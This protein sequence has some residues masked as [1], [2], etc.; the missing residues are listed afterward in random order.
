MANITKIYEVKLQGSGVLIDEMKQ[1]NKEFTSA[2]EKWKQLKTLISSG[3]LSTAETAKFKAEM[4]AAKLETERLRQEQIRLKNETIALGNANKQTAG[5]SAK[6][7]DGITQAKIET[8][9]LRQET[10]K[11]KNESLALSNAQK[12]QAAEQRKAKEET[13][14][15]T[16]AWKKL[17]AQLNSARNAAKTAGATFGIDSSEFK[18]AA[19]ISNALDA[20]VK[21]IES[22]LGQFQR[23][24]GNYPGNQMLQGLN[25]NTLQALIKS[26]FGS[27]IANQVNLAKERTKELDQQFTLLKN[28]LSAVRTN[29]TGDLDAIQREIMENRVEAQRLNT[30]IGR[31]STEFRNATS[32]GARMSQN[33]QNFFKNLR[34]EITTFLLGYLSFQ[35][36]MAKT[37]ELI[38]NTYELAD[39][40]TSLEVELGKAAGG[41]QKLVDE[42][43][44]LDTRTKLP[45]LVNMGNI[46][47][48]AG[49]EESDVVGVVSAVDKI[50]IAFG[51]DFGEVEKG[52]EDLVKLINVF[53]GG[54]VTEDL[55]LRT[56]NAV[57]TIANE[58]VASV[59][60]LNDFAKRMAG[61]KGI[62][63]IALPAVLGMASGFEQFGQSAETTST[64]IV[65]ILPKIASDVDKFAKITK[66]SREEFS[67][68][69]NESPDQALIKVAEALTKDKKGLEDLIASFR[70]S[71]LAGKGGAGITS[72]IGVL[73]KNA[74]TFQKS[75]M[76]AKNAYA[77]TSNI[78]DAFAKKNENLSASMDK[79]KKGF[80]DA[81]NNQ[82]FQAFLRGSIALITALGGAIGAIPLFAWY[83]LVGLLT[84]AYY[85]NIKA[86][87]IS[88][89]Q[90][91]VYAARTVIGNAL[92][93]ASNVLLRAQT[94][95]IYLAN[96]AW[97]VL[98]STMLYLGTIFPALRT[99]WINLNLTMLNTPIGYIVAGIAA[100]GALLVAMS[101]TTE[102]ASEAIRRNGQAIKQTAAE[103]RVNA[104]VTR[105][106]TEATAD[107][108]SKFETLTRI[109][110]DNNINLNTR[111]T[112]LQEL[113]NLNPQYLNT[114]TLENIKTKEGTDL[115]RK[116]KD[117][118]LDVAKAKASQQL[119]DDKQKK[120]IENELKI[121]ELNADLSKRYGKNVGGFTQAKNAI[122]DVIR[123]YASDLGMGDGDI[124]KQIINLTNENKKLKEDTDV[125]LKKVVDNT[126]KGLT[127]SITGGSAEV[128]A[129]KTLSALRAEVQA[130]QEEFDQTEVKSK[131]WYELQKDIA[132][133]NAYIDSLTKKDKTPKDKASRL[134]G[135]QKDFVKD[136]DAAN[137]DRL[138]AIEDNFAKG[139][140]LEDQ[141]IK[142]SLASNIKY[143]DAKI[144]YLK[145]GNAEERKQ[146]AQAGYDKAKMERE[147]NDKLFALSK[148]A[149]D[150]KLKNEEYGNQKRKDQVLNNPYST[151]L[152]KLDA[153]KK[154]SEESLATQ[155]KYNLDMLF[156]QSQYGKKSVEEMNALYRTL[157]EKQEE[158]NRNSKEYRIKVTRISFNVS[159]N[160]ADDI[161]NANEIAAAGDRKLI[162]QSKELTNAQKKIEL[163][164]IAA[165]L[166]LQNTNT[167]LGN[168]V[169]KISLLENE[170]TVRE[171]TN[172]EM[173]EYNRLLKE[174]QVLEG[175]KAQAEQNS[176]DAGAALPSGSGIPGSGVSGL[177]SSLTKSIAGKDGKI[178]IGD[179]DYSEQAGYAIAQAFDMAQQSMN[180]YFDAERNRIEQSK[181]LAYERIDLET[182]QQMRF[183]QSSAERERI[184][185]EAA[186]K[187]KK[188]DKEAGEKLKKTKKAEAKIAFLMQLANIWSTVWS[189]G[190]PIA[191]AILGAALSVMAGV[192]YA[193]TV[194]G[195]DS[196]QYKR[197]GKFLGSGGKLNGPSHSDGGMPVYDPVTGDKVAEMEGNEGII[198]ARSMSDSNTYSVSGTPSQIASKINSIGGGVDWDGGATMKKYLNGGTYLGSNLQ[199][200]FIKSYYETANSAVVF[201]GNSE[202]FDR[203]ES[204]IEDL[205]DL[206]KQE[207]IKKVFVSG[208]DIAE[209]QK[210]RQKRTEIATL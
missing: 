32:M 73:G 186:E 96:A 105:K 191:A 175:K 18:R 199:A 37:Q 38:Q 91:V 155:T 147:A 183:A 15:S 189:I 125:L 8:E 123:G 97:T 208:K 198:N 194:K 162:I 154:F 81:A 72:T 163:D 156:L 111:K 166:E 67:K 140:I 106:A 26:G 132:Q 190:N 159:D 168:V 23:N 63:D 94:I 12:Q 178:M 146:V 92:I 142:E 164:K 11:L 129:T 158:E 167:E 24:V 42:L 40:V 150:D 85:E 99:A 7:K 122:T 54:R 108:I 165:R 127:K 4:A 103:M 29:A 139:K 82:N 209:D 176:T 80:V 17:L 62:S 9:K 181:Q 153:E 75:I 124:G 69:L 30:E 34:A 76:S 51:K 138:S 3:G 114:L 55:M 70:D 193:S 171:L 205:A 43:A 10:I 207:S 48:K 206:Q 33:F 44:K 57:R 68:L 112:A 119:L 31:I 27:I 21:Q 118:L 45:E 52:T 160:L 192:Q 117:M 116:Y 172:D 102:E 88:I 78:T 66:M 53:E 157:E 19:E 95:A 152:E 151:E 84:F 28:K 169:A 126:T 98:N 77:D 182:K 134:T 20:K 100:I 135:T 148:K 104:E 121:S 188:A 180:S 179:K 210:D 110:K 109:I 61:L 87:A 130:L 144:A 184:E 141:F 16:D 50:K 35:T 128:Q 14:Q 203:I 131:R 107:S 22:R 177:A 115:L 120:I 6:N 149:V 161:T 58:S 86:L 136:L 174:R 13:N 202:R 83:T 197:G 65:R 41:A 113:I 196:T 89:G 200:P 1:V 36:A 195:I 71:D 60:F 64:A 101:A 79:L 204:K 137:K 59:P 56:G 39:G 173:R 185:K 74:D 47:I 90:T 133:K 46:A 5:D 49:V 170:M 187:K 145:K 93:T 201:A 25:E 2:S 143:F